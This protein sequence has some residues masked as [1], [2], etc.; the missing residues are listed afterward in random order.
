VAVSRNR[1]AISSRGA[2]IAR[3]QRHRITRR[4]DHRIAESL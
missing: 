3:S 1:A 2:Y 4:P